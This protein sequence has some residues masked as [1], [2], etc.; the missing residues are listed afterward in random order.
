VETVSSKP[1]LKPSRRR[2]LKRDVE[3][4]IEDPE[5]TQ[6]V[7]AHRA[8][9]WRDRVGIFLSVICLIHCLM[10]PIVLGM[11]PVG[12]ALGFW[13]HGFHQVFLVLVPLVALIAFIPGWKQHGDSRVWYWGAAGIALLAA[14]V[15]FAEAFGHGEPG[16]YAPLIGELA[17]TMAGGS[18]LIR[19]HLLN[20]ALCACCDHGHDHAH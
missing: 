8:A 17:L 19:A 11:I 14:G 2:S 10:T 13:E 9:D 6:A 4:L 16:N 15:A 1:N 20:R 7:A 12:V 18:C 3:F 5:I